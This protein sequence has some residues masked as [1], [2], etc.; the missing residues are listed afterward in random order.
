MTAALSR[1]AE[2]AA[3][4]GPGRRGPAG[5]PAGV[6]IEK[7]ELVRVSDGPSR[8]GTA[9]WNVF[10]LYYPTPLENECGRSL[11]NTSEHLWLKTSP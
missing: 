1:Q 6:I 2:T 8:S 7:T 11:K 5:G 10:T 3:V 9:V 4:G